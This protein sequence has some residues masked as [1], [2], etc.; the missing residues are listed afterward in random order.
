MLL[1]FGRHRFELGI[2]HAQVAH[3]GVELLALLRKKRLE[4]LCRCGILDSGILN[5][6]VHEITR[7]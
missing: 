7:V 5:C 3:Q 2:D 6:S 4:L 1:A